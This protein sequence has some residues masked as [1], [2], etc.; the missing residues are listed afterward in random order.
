MSA[1]RTNRNNRER[2]KAFENK[3]AKFLGWWRIPYSGSSE[4]YGLGDI[5]DHED[6]NK[7]RYI[8]E[9]KSI[10]PRSVKEINYIIQEKWLVGKDSVVARAKKQGNKLPVLFFT[11]VR[12]ALSFAIIRDKDFKMMVDALELLRRHGII[13][14][15]TDVD[16]IRRQIEG[17]FPMEGDENEESKNKSN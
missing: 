6:Q 13:D 8:G 3:M 11:K 1:S 15:T 14:D 10:T 16:E 5:R 2:G 12:S 17:H 7:A 9:C 4:L